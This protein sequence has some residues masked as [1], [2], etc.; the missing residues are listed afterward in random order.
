[1]RTKKQYRKIMAR[2]FEIPSD[3]RDVLDYKARMRR[4]VDA[5]YPTASPAIEVKAF[6][7][8]VKAFGATIPVVAV[9]A[10][11]ELLPREPVTSAQ[12]QAYIDGDTDWRT[13]GCKCDDTA[14]NRDCA[15]HGGIDDN[16]E[17]LEG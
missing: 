7:R 8:T 6:K 10:R 2:V 12:S 4:Q 14:G 5:L 13:A 11:Q 15:A 1:M 16:S 17:P 9:V 3:A